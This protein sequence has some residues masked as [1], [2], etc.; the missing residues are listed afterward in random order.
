MN[1]YKLNI[2]VI[3]N[4]L[5]DSQL[6]KILTLVE[7]LDS[8]EKTEGSQGFWDNR[9][10]SN[11]FI[12]YN[13]DKN[14]GL[15]LLE[16]RNMI[17]AEI[18]KAYGIKKIYSDHLSVCR[19]SDGISLNPHIDDMTDS[20][21]KDS[22]WFNH[23]EFGSVLYLNDNFSGGETYYVHH[24]KE[25]KPKAGSLVIHPGDESHRH[26]V[27]ATTN[28]IRYTLSSFWTQDIEYLDEFLKNEQKIY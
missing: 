21:E 4:F 22:F 8:W 26:G 17:A 25:I 27:R 7:S 2:K 14:V 5:T 10:L 9:T 19:W 28:G 3:E 24:D 18:Q 20:N 12:Y 15:E 13:L 11:E 6:S 1:S 16:I 23:R